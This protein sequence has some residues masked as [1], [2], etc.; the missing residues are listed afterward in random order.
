MG[1]IQ[2]AGANIRTRLGGALRDTGLTALVALGV[3]LPLVGFETVTD[4]NNVLILTTRWPLLFALVGSI[5]AVRFIYGLILAPRF[6]RGTLRL[7]SRASATAAR[8]PAT[9]A[10]G[11]TG[12]SRSGSARSSVLALAEAS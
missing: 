7:P 4:I 8:A 3:F 6:E 12:T 5:A 11:S 9:S 1:D 2:L 10:G